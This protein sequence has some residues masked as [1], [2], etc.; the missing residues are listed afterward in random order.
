MHLAIIDPDPV[1]S[2]VLAY[3]AQRRGHQVLCVGAAERLASNLPFKPSVVVLALDRLDNSTVR[4]VG[5]VK[6]ALP[7]AAVIVTAEGPLRGGFSLAIQSGA[8]DLAEAPYHPHELVLK[9]E[10][11]DSA[12]QRSAQGETALR[13]ADLEVDLSKYLV[14][15]AGKSLVLTKLELRLLYCLMEH[16]PNLAPIERLLTFGW[17]VLS[18]PD[19]SLIKTHMSHLRKKLEEAG[20]VQFEIQSRQTVGYI[21]SYAQ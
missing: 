20:G 10:L 14:V 13:L 8:S 6:K 12:L 9:A 11:W 19:A 1:A 2:Y 18:N 21:L 15:K 7:E 3:A 4:S 5:T 17:D 16:H